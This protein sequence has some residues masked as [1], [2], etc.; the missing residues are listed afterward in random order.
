[1][2]TWSFSIL[3]YLKTEFKLFRFTVS[4]LGAPFCRL[5]VLALYSEIIS[6]KKR[7]APGCR[8]TPELSLFKVG[9]AG[10]GD[11]LGRGVPG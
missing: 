8:G 6:L 3:C 9:L 1:M 2:S 11:F 10:L 5:C 7:G 4:F